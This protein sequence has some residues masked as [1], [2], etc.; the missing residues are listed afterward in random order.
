[1]RPPNKLITCLLPLCLAGGPLEA[2]TARF[3]FPAGDARLALEPGVSNGLW[4]RSLS[5]AESQISYVYRQSNPSSVNRLGLAMELGT[6]SI[7]SV[8]SPLA[9]L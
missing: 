8:F 4:V 6:L 3:S 7:R 5:I 1:M 2:L 9:P